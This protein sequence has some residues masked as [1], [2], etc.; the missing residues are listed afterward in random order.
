MI[1]LGVYENGEVWTDVAGLGLERA[2][3]LASGPARRQVVLDVTKE[4][5]FWRAGGGRSNLAAPDPVLVAEA[6]RAAIGQ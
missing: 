5:A 6:V 4:W 1:A 3:R 2:R